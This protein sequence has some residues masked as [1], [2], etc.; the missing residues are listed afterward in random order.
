[1]N[2]IIKRQVGWVSAI[3]LG[4]LMQ[5]AFADKVYVSGFKGIQV[6]DTDSNSV[7]NTLYAV[8]GDL[9][10]TSPLHDLVV[11]PDGTRLYVAS[12][13]ERKLSV[14]DTK[15][16]KVLN[17]IPLSHRTYYE[18][19]VMVNP[20]GTQVYVLSRPQYVYLDMKAVSVV[21]TVLNKEIAI[22]D[23]SDINRIVFNPSGEYFY[24]FLA[25]YFNIGNI[26]VFS[27]NTNDLITTIS[28]ND[29][30]MNGG[31]VAAGKNLYLTTTT[32]TSTSYEQ[33]IT[34]I[35]AQSNQVIANIP[36]G[37]YSL[38]DD[39]QVNSEGT[40]LYA[41]ALT[42]VLVFNLT[43]NTLETTIP[44]IGGLCFG[45]GINAA[46][47]RIYVSRVNYNW[48]SSML[49]VIDAESNKIVSTVSLP[50]T[51][52]KT[53]M[54]VVSSATTT[55][56]P[57]ATA[58]ISNLN[59]QAQLPIIG[60]FGI[61]GTGTLNLLFQGSASDTCISPSMTLRKYP[62][63]EVVD[64]YY[65]ST[66][67]SGY[68]N[69]DHYSHPS[70]GMD[71]LSSNP[72]DVALV[73]DLPAGY[74]TVSLDAL[75]CNEQGKLSIDLI[76]EDSSSS[77]KLTNFN[78]NAMLPI[79]SNVTVKG[80]GNIQTM[81][82]GFKV[83][84]CVDANLELKNSPSGTLFANNDNWESD[85]NVRLAKMLPNYLQPTDS[86]DAG[87]LRTLFAQ[88][89]TATLTSKNT[90]QGDG[91]FGVDVTHEAVDDLLF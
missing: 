26:P 61:S 37:G 44:M 76:E 18:N 79:T 52:G 31:M 53:R 33:F 47:T 11:N 9:N 20:S 67:S 81:F 27:A 14:I 86:S 82:R 6:I 84:P 60:G 72:K 59:A 74:Y 22:L 24:G 88:S 70:T 83:A 15:T 78:A 48:S 62:S 75:G 35:N 87:L 90:C 49:Y 2:T 45:M 3:A 91:V 17:D 28:L 66:Y 71:L 73:W 5:A 63:G 50:S 10:N 41:C 65:R 4:L 64:N 25:A 40:R 54:A 34:V 58:R 55:P 46:G 23:L 68:M 39:I 13:T 43:N 29:R 1:M 7:I 36:T 8:G 51:V 85:V 32:I 56:I 30:W 21:D 57:R 69:G 80:T 16:D 19:S 77:A 38:L 89:V 12:D 42:D